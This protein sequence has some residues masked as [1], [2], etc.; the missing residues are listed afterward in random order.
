[1]LGCFELSA[2]SY[3]ELYRLSLIALARVTQES[4]E[5]T[6]E[7]SCAVTI[8]PPMPTATHQ[9]EY[10]T[11]LAVPAGRL[12]PLTTPETKIAVHSFATG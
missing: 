9:P 10:N 8:R 5:L 7:L 11:V 6:W 4:L 2:R 12:V 3:P 1:M